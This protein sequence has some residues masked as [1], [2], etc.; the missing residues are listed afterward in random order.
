MEDLAVEPETKAGGQE[1]SRFEDSRSAA[2][3]QETPKNPSLD[4]N[5]RLVYCGKILPGS[6]L[7]AIRYT[8][9]SFRSLDQ[10]QVE[11]LLLA[12]GRLGYQI[13][14]E[15]CDNL[16]QTVSRE[17]RLPM[18][19]Q[20]KVDLEDVRKW[21]KIC[22]EHHRGRCSIKAEPWFV[23]FKV[24]DCCTMGIVKAPE[25][26]EYVALSYLWGSSAY[27]AQD[28]LSSLRGESAPLTIRDAVVVV[29]ELGFRYLWIDRYCINQSDGGEKHDIIQRMDVIYQCASITIIAAGGKGPDAGLSGVSETMRKLDLRMHGGYSRPY[30]CLPRADSDI[31]ESI[32]WTRAWT[33][34]EGL[35]SRRRLVF[36]ESQVY[37]QCQ[38][39]HYIE[40][41]RDSFEKTQEPRYS[42]QDDLNGHRVFPNQGVGEKTEDIFVRI[43]EYVQRELSYESDGLNAFLGLFRAYQRMPEPVYHFWGVPLL[44]RSGAPIASSMANGLLWCSFHPSDPEH[45]RLRRVECLPSWSWVG[46]K[47]SGTKSPGYDGDQPYWR[48]YPWSY[49]KILDTDATFQVCL[50][51]SYYNMAEYV[52]KIQAGIR[53]SDFKPKIW[54]R[55]WVTRLKL[56]ELGQKDSR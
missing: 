47:W 19:Y 45:G 17:F 48:Y 44:A 15:I 43:G 21:L 28:S 56:A 50:R 31:Q 32:W 25:G 29:K 27:D 1:D 36:T 37:F 7:G 35:L 14:K 22:K 18:T 11:T 13:P 9:K 41:W 52:E 8:V 54:V 33:Y 55:G 38:S 34:Q 39:G 5:S 46:W 49:D 10:C 24:I 23:G 40:K 20:E 16:G 12:D 6:Q 3:Q 26:C 30:I 42:F 53:F 4:E 51:E 2:D